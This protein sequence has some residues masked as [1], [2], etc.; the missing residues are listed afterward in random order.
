[1]CKPGEVCD[2]AKSYFDAKPNMRAMTEEFLAFLVES[3]LSSIDCVPLAAFPEAART[4]EGRDMYNQ[5]FGEDVMKYAEEFDMA[6]VTAHAASVL[7][8]VANHAIEVANKKKKQHNDAVT[9]MI[10]EVE[11]DGTAMVDME[12]RSPETL[13]IRRAA[14]ISSVKGR[15]RSEMVFDT[16]LR[17]NRTKDKVSV[18]VFVLGD[19]AQKDRINNLINEAVKQAAE[20]SGVPEVLSMTIDPST[21]KR[22]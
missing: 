12:D 20:E 8:I 21:T 19:N 6:M 16:I 13:P 11:D 17:K 3:M 5:Q 4:P 1:M 9:A 14:M 10:G 15:S 18:A 22:G 2:N 7:M